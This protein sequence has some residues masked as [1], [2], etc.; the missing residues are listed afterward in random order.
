MKKIVKVLITGLWVTL[1]IGS[2]T[3]VFAATNPIAFK[4]GQ[5]SFLVPFQKVSGT[6]L[7]SFHDGKGFPGLETTLYSFQKFQVTFGAAATL[8]TSNAVPFI[9]AQFRLPEK[10]FDVGNNDLMFGA[11]AAKEQGRK[12]LTVGIKASTNL[13]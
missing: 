6:Q 2:R 3:G 10:F 12:G 8:G 7:Y 9:G 4:V 13:W 5:N 11:Y 1:A